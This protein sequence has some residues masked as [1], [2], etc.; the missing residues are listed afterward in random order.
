MILFAAAGGAEISAYSIIKQKIKIKALKKIIIIKALS[1][2]RGPR[3]SRQ[4]VRG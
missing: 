2:A 4:L 3:G 1:E